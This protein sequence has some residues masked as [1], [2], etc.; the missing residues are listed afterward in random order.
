MVVKQV[1]ESAQHRQP[2]LQIVIVQSGGR[3]ERTVGPAPMQIE[4]MRWPNW[5]RRGDSVRAVDAVRRRLREA[6]AEASHAR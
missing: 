5:S 4:P 2:G 1:V 3:I 6:A